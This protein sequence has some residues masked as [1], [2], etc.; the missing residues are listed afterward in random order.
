MSSLPVGQKRSENHEAVLHLADRV[1]SCV[2]SEQQFTPGMKLI[3]F[4]IPSSSKGP[5]IHRLFFLKI[6]TP[7]SPI[8]LS[9]FFY[10]FLKV[11]NSSS[12]V[13]HST[14][15]PFILA[16]MSFSF[17]AEIQMSSMSS[18]WG[19]N[20]ASMMSLREN[21]GLSNSNLNLVRFSILVQCLNF[22]ALLDINSRIG[23]MSLKSSM[24]FLRSWNAGHSW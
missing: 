24:I 11:R 10:L 19:S 4:G 23:Q 21:P 5:S 6:E 20:G 13:L 2:P 16:S 9:C 3:Q 22:I 14:T 18:L 15:T 8:L 12:W 1:C 7:K 17:M